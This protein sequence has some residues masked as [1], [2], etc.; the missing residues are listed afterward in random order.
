MDSGFFAE[1][2]QPFRFP[3]SDIPL[4]ADVD[5]DGMQ[6]M[7][8]SWNSG[9]VYAVHRGDGQGNY[10]S[11][12]PIAYRAFT[13]DRQP[14][15]LSDLDGDGDLDL[16]GVDGYWYENAWPYFLP[17][18]VAGL[19]WAVSGDFNADGMID[20]ASDV[21][22]HL[23]L[24]GGAFAEPVAHDIPVR[25]IWTPG[26][27]K[28]VDGDGDADLVF[29]RHWYQ[30][31]GLEF[32]P[33]ELPWRIEHVVDFDG[34]GRYELLSEGE[35]GTLVYDVSRDRSFQ[36]P[37]TGKPVDLDADG[38]LDF[39]SD[40]VCL[41]DGVA[42]TCESIINGSF[43]SVDAI[44]FDSDGAMDIVVSNHIVV[45][46]GNSVSVIYDVVRQL[47]SR[48]SGDLDGSGTV[49][50][51]DFLILSSQFGQSEVDTALIGDLDRDGAVGFADFLILSDRFG[52]EI[53]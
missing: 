30:N 29:R 40:R 35:E 3:L 23:N 16:V 31:A 10:E 42:F 18:E 6:D 48:R 12:V 26:I 41:N 5:G 21:G 28:D 4:F 9:F 49:D 51:A 11:A 43:T 19:R 22:V 33:H 45:A 32:T 13:L 50:F 15:S 47:E 52:S 8:T 7:V 20:L 53:S 17:R 14:P 34:D 25:G 44:D 1:S 38:D 46:R 39:L 37:V 27:A 24:G 2:S 36:L